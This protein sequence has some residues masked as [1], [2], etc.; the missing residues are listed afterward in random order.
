[1]VLCGSW[2]SGPP[3]TVGRPTR[4]RPGGAGV[5]PRRRAPHPHR[6]CP[7]AHPPGCCAPRHP[8]PAEPRPR[9]GDRPRPRGHR[10][11]AQLL[12]D[13]DQVD[14]RF[15]LLATQALRTHDEH[16]PIP[17]PAGAYRVVRQREYTPNRSAMS[18]T[19]PGARRLEV[20]SPGQEAL[21]ALVG[22]EW[23]GSAW[24]PARP[25]APRPSRGA[26]G[27]PGRRAPPTQPAGLAGS[28]L[29]G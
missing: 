10:P 25:T 7:A 11:T 9:G 8:R 23:L 20:L 14:R 6:S 19:D 12:A 3:A 22:Q 26:A 18:P 4:V 28:P 17:L 24:P 5:P 27:L 21:L 16:A 1:V 13:P 29:A 2:L 15:L